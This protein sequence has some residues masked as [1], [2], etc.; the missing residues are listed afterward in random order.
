MSDYPFDYKSYMDLLHDDDYIALYDYY[1]KETM[2][3]ILGVAR[4]ENPHSSFLRWLLD[5]NSEHGYGSIPMRNFFHTIC[6]MN[7]EIYAG[8]ACENPTDENN[9]LG[10]DNDYLLNEIQYGRY[11]IIKQY[12]VTEL[13]LEGK[14]RA[15]IVAVAQ[16]KFQR[17]NEK[18]NVRNILIL[19]ENKIHSYE[20]DNQTKSYVS[21]LKSPKVVK[22]IIENLPFDEADIKT[23]IKL[24]VYLN[25]FSTTE[26]KFNAKEKNTGQLKQF[27]TS[28]D[29]ITINYQSLLDGLIEPLA[30]ISTDAITTQRIN[31]YI[32]CLGQAKITS[33]D[34]ETEKKH[35]HN[36]I[37]DEY[38]IMAVSNHEQILARQLWGKYHEVILPILESIFNEAQ[39]KGFILRESEK[40]FWLSIAN[41]YRFM[42]IDSK[43][44]EIVKN[45]NKRS[46]F[47]FNELEYISNNRGRNIGVLARDI[48][49]DFIQQHEQQCDIKS[50]RRRLQEKFRSNWLKEVILFESEIIKIKN[51]YEDYKKEYEGKYKYLTENIADFEGYFFSDKNMAIKLENGDFAYVAKYWSADGIEELIKMLDSV[52]STSYTTKVERVS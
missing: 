4:Q 2:M 39:Y 50:L 32:R 44:Q 30:H 5:M 16:L 49:C 37:N 25:A 23:A 26:L 35:K 18:K 48:I 10:K 28:S 45:S 40:D 24:Y 52:Y 11:E 3:G 46:K 34:K 9:L 47:I 12:I 38:L 20:H 51:N 27:A 36:K 13:V 19:I 1:S 7:N 17:F 31:D 43:L 6:F 29:Y 41:L 14:R 33:M 42:E 21:D 8:A 22:K 15:D